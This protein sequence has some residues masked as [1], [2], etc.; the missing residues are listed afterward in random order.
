MQRPPLSVVAK[1]LRE[2]QWTKEAQSALLRHEL[3]DLS[4]YR[5]FEEPDALDLMSMLE[6][7]F[8]AL[9]AVPQTLDDSIIFL[10]FAPM[11]S[12]YRKLIVAL[13]ERYRLRPAQFG[14]EKECFVVTYKHPGSVCAPILRIED[15]VHAAS[16]FE[17]PPPPAAQAY[18]RMYMPRQTRDDF[19]FEGTEVPLCQDY[20]RWTREGCVPAPRMPPSGYQCEFAGCH[21]HI[22]ELS[23]FDPEL[24]PAGLANLAAACAAAR[25]LPDGV[26]LVFRTRELAEAFVR[27][28]STQTELAE[29]SSSGGGAVR[30]ALS[31]GP[32]RTQCSAR[33]L[34][35]LQRRPQSAQQGAGSR[36]RVAPRG[37][38]FALK[39]A[40]ITPRKEAKSL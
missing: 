14:E 16:Y 2:V 17:P 28:H 9:L 12:R 32:L 24:D 23:S 20:G 21:E 27:L 4:F 10:R 40:G 29:S 18:K 37:F 38:T 30:L 11:Q 31:L 7:E 8:D 13:A 25:P 22:L 1:P 19:D 39:Q 34:A 35:S 5:R 3:L 33:A 6:R 36:P 15:F 26:L